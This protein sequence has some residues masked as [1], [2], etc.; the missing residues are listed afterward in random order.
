MLKT[1][2]NSIEG[3]EGKNEFYSKR[4]KEGSMED[5]VKEIIESN[6]SYKDSMEELEAMLIREYI[7]KNPNKTHL[8][9]EMGISRQ[10]LINKLKK[11]GIINV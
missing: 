1:D 9:K 4:E 8:A 6:D 10:S 2:S 3:T 5:Y 7:K 11:Y